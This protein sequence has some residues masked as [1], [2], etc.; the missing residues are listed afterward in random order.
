MKKNS[1]STISKSALAL[2]TGGT[3]TGLVGATSLSTSASATSLCGG[4]ATKIDATTCETTY[5][6]T[7]VWTPPAGVTSVQALLV[8]GGGDGALGVNG[9]NYGYGG[10]GGAVMVVDL[11]NSTPASINPGGSDQNTVVT[12][13]VSTYTANAGAAAA[14]Y[15]PAT[16]GNGNSGD[17]NSSGGGGGGAGAGSTSPDGGAGAIVSTIAPQGSLFSN[18]TNCYGGGGAGADINTDFGVPGCGAGTVSAYDGVAAASTPFSGAG[19]SASSANFVTGASGVVVIRYSLKAP[20]TVYFATNSAAIST[21]GKAVLNSFAAHVVSASLP[22][23]IV[24]GYTDPRGTPAA[25][26]ILARKRV[27]AVVAYLHHKL[28][29]LNYTSETFTQVPVGITRKGANYAQDRKVTLT[30]P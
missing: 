5:H 24:S 18:D 9:Q 12:Q 14:E 2:L 30:T 3:A 6:G 7:S 4:G 25:N 11:L 8:G 1:I 26:R 27:S 10:G 23:I 15:S 28:Q 16:S 21:S 13:G 17:T 19:G 22:K 29:L 20:P